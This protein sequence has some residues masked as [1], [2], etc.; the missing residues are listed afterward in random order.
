MPT[1]SVKHTGVLSTL[2]N[3][4]DHGSFLKGFKVQLPSTESGLV[5]A[6]PRCPQGKSPVKG[7]VAPMGRIKPFF[8]SMWKGIQMQRSNRDKTWRMNQINYSC[9]WKWLDLLNKNGWCKFVQM[10]VWGVCWKWLWCIEQTWG[11][12]WGALWGDWRL[13]FLRGFRPEVF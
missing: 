6:E 12:L 8:R 13:G 3:N 9:Y 1:V 7:L 10:I 11:A 4:W 5:Q 2:Q